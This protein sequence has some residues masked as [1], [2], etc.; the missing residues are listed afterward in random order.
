M[1]PDQTPQCDTADNQLVAVWILYMALVLPNQIKGCRVLQVSEPC[2]VFT[3]NLQVP[4][5]DKTAVKLA[6]LLVLAPAS[7]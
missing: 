3:F 4:D 6:S 1:I 2:Q 5:V 7:M